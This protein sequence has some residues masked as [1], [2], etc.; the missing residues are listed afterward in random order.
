MTD[1]PDKAVNILKAVS[2][3]LPIIAFF[4]AIFYMW[5]TNLAPGVRLVSLP[6]LI[7]ASICQLCAFTIRS[8][9]LL[10]LLRRFGA[11]LEFAPTL[12]C[13]FKPVLTKYVPGKIWLLVST[14]GMLHNHGISVAR[15]SAV[16]L[17]FQAVLVINGL[18][19]GTIALI[20]FQL[21]GLS[22]SYRLVLVL[23]PMGLLA[24]LLGSGRFLGRLQQHYPQLSEKLSKGE[25][26]PSLILPTFLTL[27]HWII[28][29][30]AFSLFL[31]SVGVHAGLY[32]LLFQPLAIN[33]GVLAVI[34]PGGLGVREGAMAA[35]LVL[36]EI[37]LNYGLVLAV[38]AR[39]WFFAG[40][41]VA[42]AIGIMLERSNRGS[43]QEKPA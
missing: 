7:A 31:L 32:P 35:Y 29:G 13:T 10:D 24:I 23:L 2:L 36:A 19:L 33:L 39:I 27:I 40:E 8:Y 28:I 30:L 16:V 41:L 6:L 26:F 37:P 22:E 11:P 1:S 18:F 4:A 25:K 14:V 17:V 5:Q 21:P 12:S 20:A 3:W 42:F 15:A 9:V 34:V 43:Q 38:A